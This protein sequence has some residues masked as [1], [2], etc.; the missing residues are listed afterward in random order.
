M[1]ADAK[2]LLLAIL[3]DLS[4]RARNEI[5][6]VYRTA[7]ILPIILERDIFPLASAFA[8]ARRAFERE[9]A[10]AQRLATIFNCA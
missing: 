5:S 7:R 3:G 4:A 8:A 9:R 6:N 2:G 10:H 1:K